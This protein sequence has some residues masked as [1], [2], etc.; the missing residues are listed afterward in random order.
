[1]SQGWADSHEKTSRD[2][3]G[4]PDDSIPSPPTR[5][6]GPTLDSMATNVDPMSASAP[7]PS[8]GFQ[9]PHSSPFP[10]DA[11]TPAPGLGDS[12]GERGLVVIEPGLTIFGKYLVLERLGK[13]GMGEV[14]LVK[15]VELDVKRAL[16]MITQGTAFNTEAR[17]RFRREARAMARFTHPNVVAVHDSRLDNQ[18]VAYI[19]M[20]YVAGKSLEKI[21]RPG[22][23]MSLEWTLHV[24]TQL[25]D[26]LDDAHG[27]GIIHRDLK[28]S[29]M[30]LV[31]TPSKRD[32]LKVLDFGIAK[33]LHTEE[34]AYEPQTMAGTFIG[35]P[36]YASPEQ[37]GG[38]AVPVSDIYSL[39]V[40]LFEFLT[41]SR[42]FRGGASSMV[43]S[44]LF[45][46]PP[47]FAE[48]NAEA[49][50]PPEIERVVMRCLAKNPDDRPQ[51]AMEVLR[52]FKSAM[53]TVEHVPDAKEQA[54]EVPD[55]ALIG[56]SRKGNRAA[57][58]AV[59]MALV[60]V[61]AILAA[62]VPGMLKSA[63]KTSGQVEPIATASTGA[64]KDKPTPV[65][66]DRPEQFA[67]GGRSFRL[68]QGKFYLPVGYEPVD[69]SGAA[70]DGWPA[71]IVRKEDDVRFPRIPGGTFKM[72]ARDE[73]DADS[74]NKPAHEV[75]VKGFYLQKHEVTN[76][77]MLAYE[78]KYGKRFSDPAAL[79]SW[80]E[81]YEAVVTAVTAASAS[82][83]PAQSIS[84]TLADDYA[85]KHS[86]WLPTEAQWEY[87][88][89]SGESTRVLVW[90]ADVAQNYTIE[91]LSNL[92]QSVPKNGVW[93]SPV[94]AFPQDRT[95]RG[96]M[97]MAGNLREW[98]RDPWVSYEIQ[99][100]KGLTV[101][102]EKPSPDTVMVV[103]G[104]SFAALDFDTK[105]MTRRGTGLRVSEEAPQ[106]VG[107]RLVVEC[108]EPSN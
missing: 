69:Q 45:S 33:I 93:P 47:T 74:T 11:A 64:D 108:P 16:K 23:P 34:N 2:P 88:A 95:R 15:D 58:V 68:W 78:E 48:M 94:G 82:K 39:G 38:L 8:S 43:S 79:S 71:E 1:M 98:C 52:E 62:V 107:F 85:R 6:G 66:K 9:D 90:D 73:I 30:I 26:A 32:V 84:W 97:D 44:T 42:P 19:V 55:T 103:R 31:D 76:G 61:V 100:A 13:G 65:P 83:Y 7:F 86:G 29:N 14:W 70:S 37:V 50:V 56:S 28:P 72:G 53:P 3:E 22:H 12:S 4:A 59:A 63:G 87:A 77:E 10:T 106:D 105:L 49:D 25:C 75:T 99:A 57:I 92:A 104:S 24:L 20:E 102:P 41:G 51:S 35:T 80:R 18:D 21:L 101:A 89:R 36:P 5:L 40:M 91:K 46:P 96:V 67:E 54:N 17:V 81:R 27:Q 60:A